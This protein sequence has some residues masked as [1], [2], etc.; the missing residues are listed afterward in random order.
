MTR[1]K[2]EKTVYP[3]VRFRKHPTRKHGVTA[4]R[5]F[6][7]R[8]SVDGRKVEEGL[9]WAS[10]G[11][12]A[13]KAFMYLAELKE[14]HKTGEGAQ[15][16][17]ERRAENEKRIHDTLTFGGYFQ[18][19]YF[20]RAQTSKKKKSYGTERSLFTLWI[21]PVIGKLTFQKI[22]PIHLERIKSNMVKAGKSAATQRYAQAVI[23][24]VWTLARRDKIVSG[25]SPTKQV[26]IRK[27]DNRRIRFLSLDEAGILLAELEKNSE[28]LHDMALLSLHSGLRAGEIFNLTWDCLDPDRGT[29]VLKDTKSGRNRAAYMTRKV[30]AMLSRRKGGQTNGY[31]FKTQGG[32]K[33]KEI[34]N[35]FAHV[36]KEIGFNKG[37]SDSRDKVVFHTLRHSFASWLVESGVDLYTVKELLGHSSLSMT[38]RY[39]HLGENTLQNAVRRLDEITEKPGPG[40]VLSLPGK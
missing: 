14:A 36:V 7:I 35:A 11:M 24:Q 23:S 30:T 13:K 27:V 25:D 10:E 19:V 28:Q 12:T 18:Q 37:V 38:E 8:H 9:G 6:T 5:Y 3:G 17:A 2:W 21:E 4:D 20:P 1:H 40:K 32:K 22:A 15:T 16:L 29:M 33:I 26:R 39:S 31:I 34:S